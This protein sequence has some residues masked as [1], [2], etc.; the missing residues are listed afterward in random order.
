MC[1]PGY[2]SVSKLAVTSVVLSVIAIFG[3]VAL[4]FSLF[5][6]MALPVAI[7][8]RSATHRHRLRGRRLALAS[9]ALSVLALVTSPLWYIHQYNS[10]SLPSHDRVAFASIDDGIG[11]GLDRYEGR[12]ICIKGY[13]IRRDPRHRQATI[14]MSPDG[15]R[16]RPEAIISVQLPF[17]WQHADHA[18]AVS[19]ILTVNRQASEY[20]LRYTLDATDI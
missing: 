13:A 15:S 17:G 10:E 4:P 5:A 9:I 1:K 18:I 20:V 2:N 8:A 11:T 14:Y 16:L 6:I 7:V 3:Y 19:G 12:R